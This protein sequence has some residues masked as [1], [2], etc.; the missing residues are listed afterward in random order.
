MNRFQY[1]NYNGNQNGNQNNQGSYDYDVNNCKWYQ[2]SCQSYVVSSGNGERQDN[3]V[4]TPGWYSGWATSEQEREY[5][6]AMGQA[7]G[8]LKFVYIWQLLVFSG[9]LYYGFRVITKKKGF[10]GLLGMLLIWANFCFMS[11]WLLADGSI[12]TDG[13]A[14]EN[15]GFY[16]QFAVLMFMTN[17]WYFLFGLGFGIFLG[18]RAMA[19]AAD[20][21]DDEPRGQELPSSHYQAYSETPVQQQMVP[22]Q[23]QMVPVQQPVQQRDPAA[24]GE[25]EEGFVKVV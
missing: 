14:V 16:G 8:A 15:I 9:I 11:M 10:A 24:Q 23:Q 4:W 19:K 25:S 22:V 5:A 1:Y 2:F 18:L 3:Q 17:F 6:L 21:L 7:P 20:L 12:V 13:D